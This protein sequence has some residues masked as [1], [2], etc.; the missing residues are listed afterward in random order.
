MSHSIRSA[1]RGRGSI[2]VAAVLALSACQTDQADPAADSAALDTSMVATAPATSPVTATAG[3]VTD[4]QI[5][6]IVVAANTA[7]IEAGE[8]A[9][10]QAADPRVREF[11]ERMI[12]DHTAVNQQ[13]TEL[14]Q[15]LGVTP[16]E[17]PTSQQI[18]QDG[19][20]TRQRL[21]GL[22]GAEFD[23]AYI[24][25]EVSFHQTVLDALDD[26]LIPNAQNA[27]LRALLEQT[28][29]AIAAHLDAA[30]DIQ[31]SL[32]AGGTGGDTAGTGGM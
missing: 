31:G 4:P 27:E 1:I 18:A 12:T 15:R 20:Q 24:D 19:E 9:R 23:R 3:A 14:V 16:E 28:R 25:H 13:A 29:P 22:S 21:S 10:D 17:N 11:G 6:A 2:L 30:R 5:A 8:L 26:T 7:D 32:G